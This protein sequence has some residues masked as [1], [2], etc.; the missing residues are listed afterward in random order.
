MSKILI[1]I[2]A[3][4]VIVAIVMVVQQFKP[5]NLGSINIGSLFK[6]NYSVPSGLSGQKSNISYSTGGNAPTPVAQKPE[7]TP[8][9]GF[10]VAQLSPYYGE[11]KIGNVSPGS[12]NGVAQFSLNASYGGLKAPIDVTGW[13]LSSNSGQVIIP[14][15]IADYTPGGSGF[16]GDI[17]LGSGETLN[18]YSS[19]SP[20]VQNLRL[21]A[22]TGYL[23]NTYTFV[24]AL[25]QSCAAA[26]DRSAIATFSGSCQNYILSIWGCSVPT[27]NRINSFSNEPACQ[28]FLNTKFGYSACY[29]ANRF[30]PNFF[31]N[32]WDAWIG[33]PLNLDPSHDRLLLWDKQGL[34]VDEYIY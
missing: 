3:I 15:A 27:A 29:Y 6:V 5:S 22:C 25:P 33:G 26:Y 23:N 2:I 14:Q 18:V 11:I 9:A 21:N 20:I 7:P 30:Q 17:T 1:L 16:P 31:S 24:P 34:L 13:R 4:V 12:Y 10:K 32:I 8:P 19:A 28:S